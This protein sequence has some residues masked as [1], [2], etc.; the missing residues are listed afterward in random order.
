MSC[1]VAFAIGV[2]ASI[3]QTAE[4]ADNSWWKGNIHTHT[5][6]SDGDDFP[7]MIADWYR[8]HGYQF[9]ALSDHN[10]LSEGIRWMKHEEIVAIGGKDALE[11]Y[12]RR[13]GDK[14]VETR[15]TPGTSDFEVRLKTLH[16]FRPLLE[17]PGRFLMIQAEEISDRVGGLKVHM[18]AINIEDRIEPMGGRTVAE[19]IENNFR[20][21]EEQ[22]KRT[23]REVLVHLN[24]PNWGDF[25]VTAEDLAMVVRERFFEVYNGHLDVMQLGD[26]H[27][28]SVDRLWDIA[29]TIRL[30]ELAAPPLYGVATDDSHQHH[31]AK[32]SHPGRGWVMVR[33]TKLEP[34][35]LIKAIK[36]GNFYASTGVTLLDV[37]YDL[38]S[39]VFQLLIAG[40]DGETFTTEFIGTKVGYDKTSKAPVD[41]RGEPVRGTRVY[42]NDVGQILA[43]VKGESPSFRLTGNELYVRAVVTSS[44]PHHNPSFK[45]QHQQAWAQPVGWQAWLS[46]HE[47]TKGDAKTP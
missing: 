47:S 14:W 26:K 29:N 21:V 19:A 10:I 40:E 6:W 30:G 5:L 1:G 16:E 46:E 45:D 17:H 24:H 33:A 23:G 11:K 4:R 7:E 20:A 36:A 27:H 35:S 13:F 25:A 31:G 34:T 38:Q 12:K 18:N 8:N 15:G 42:S 2:F 43:T 37:N 44:R 9:L 22:A 41:E 3:A 28:P 32:G 39:K